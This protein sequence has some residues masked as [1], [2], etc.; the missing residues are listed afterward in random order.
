MNM[1]ELSKFIKSVKGN[2]KYKL[3]S[4]CCGVWIVSLSKKKKRERYTQIEKLK[5]EKKGL[6][7]P[8]EKDWVVPSSEPGLW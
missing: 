5:G 6:D 2:V 8:F 1:R 7:A 4:F 3:L